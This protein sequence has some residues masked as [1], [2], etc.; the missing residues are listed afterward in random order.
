MEYKVTM[1]ILSDTMDIGKLIKWYVK[2]GDFVHKGDKIAEIE[3]DKA[4]MD[5]ESF[6][7][8]IVKETFYKENQDVEVKSVIAVID[9]DSKESI[10]NDK[11]IK[12]SKKQKHKVDNKIDKIVTTNNLKD[13][14]L[15]SP[16]AKKEAQKIDLEIKALQENGMLPIPAHKKDIDNIYK[17]YF[18]PKAWK[19][20]KEFNIDI[21][22]FK[23][24][25][26]L[27][28]ND[29]KIY[30]QKNNCYI[31]KSLSQNRK[32]IIKN[33]QNSIK[34]PTFLMFEEIEIQEEAN[35][36]AML[37]KGVANAMQKHYLTRSVIKNDSLFIYPNSNISIA[38]NREDGLFM[39]VIS[40][41]QN[42]TLQ[43]IKEWLAEIK[44]KTLTI[45]DLSGSTFGIS[46]LGMFGIDSFSALINGDDSGIMA[47]GSL[48]KGKIKVTFTF[49]HTILNGVD[50]A[51]FVNE[52]KKEIKCMM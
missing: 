40:E 41:A 17:K 20:I 18:T 28:E 24:N 31:K 47:V 32:I 34:K 26:K 46:N 38:V 1:P 5:I 14:G 50:G 2:K 15:A 23:L 8:G 16:L 4:T 12:N 36:T 19:L 45:Y 11:N 42:K 33:V 35:I 3:S 43:E 30:I 21:G 37:I 27:S 22:E 25:H 7:D 6:V 13:L 49:D 10:K 39:C 9:T 51:N 52:I 29:I 48:K 44:T